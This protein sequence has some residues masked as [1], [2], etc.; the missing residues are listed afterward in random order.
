MKNT[1]SVSQW[2]QNVYWLRQRHPPCLIA[3]NNFT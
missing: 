1:D 2:Q 3:H